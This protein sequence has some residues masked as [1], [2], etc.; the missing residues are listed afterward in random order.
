MEL[1]T[2]NTLMKQ[3]FE[4]ADAKRAGTETKRKYGPAL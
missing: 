4:D 1:M 2:G 3:V